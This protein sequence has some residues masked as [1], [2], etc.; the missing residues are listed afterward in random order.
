MKLLINDKEIAFYLNSLLDPIDCVRG[1]ELSETKT[2]EAIGWALHRK[3]KEGQIPGKFKDKVIE[4]VTSGVRSDLTEYVDRVTTTLDNRK[5]LYQKNLHN[6]ID[7]FLDKFGEQNILNRYKASPQQYFVKSVGLALNPDSE[8]IRRKDFVDY[9]EDCLLRNTVGNEGLLVNKIDKNMPFWFIDS[10]YTNFLET[11]K[12]WHRVVRNHLHY[13]NYFEAPSD[14]LGNLKSFPA[15]WRTGGD[16]IL[17]IE[18]GPFAAAIFHADLKTWKYEVAKELRKYTDKKIYFRPKI[19]KKIRKDL[20]KKLL[21]D[22]YYCTVSINSNS[23]VESIWA[24]V[25]A[26][27][28]DKHISNPVTVSKLSDI[29]N[30]YRGPLGNWL[31]WL[32]YNQFTYE[33]LLNGTAVE[34]IRKYNV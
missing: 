6:H 29:N 9:T 16:K 30:L 21:D 31:S 24:G 13:S 7:Y 18:P 20:Y 19:D 17:I 15:E 1:I 27:T 8:L 32:T 2:A 33:E 5:R 4:K 28:L 10:G 23:A 34:L 22:D 11:N 14:R 3:N 25:P 26:I 12:K